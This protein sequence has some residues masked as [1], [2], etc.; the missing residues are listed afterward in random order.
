MKGRECNFLFP[1]EATGLCNYYILVNGVG[2][3]YEDIGFIW[4]PFK[5]INAS[6]PPE[7]YFMLK[8]NS[9]IF[10]ILK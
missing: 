8:T 5:K 9:I 6:I 3:H 10:L 2:F 4:N 7:G 1:W